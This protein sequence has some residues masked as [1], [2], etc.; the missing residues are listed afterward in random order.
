MAKRPSLSHQMF[1]RLEELKCIGESRHEAKRVAKE[2]G[3][4]VRGIYSYKTYDAYKNSSKQ[5][6]SW[7]KE[8]YNEVKY[9][10]DITADMAK[11][12]I[13]YREAEGHS[14]YTYSQDMA[15]INKTLNLNITKKDC[16]VANRNLDTIKNSRSD[17]GFRTKT[18]A[19]EQF[20]EGTGLRR[21]ELNY[22]TKKD[23]IYQDNKVVGVRVS[24]GGKGGKT[25]VA[26]VHP[27]YQKKIYTQ[28]SML[29]SDDKIIQEEIPKELQ[30]HRIRGEYAK[31]MYKELQN[32]GLSTKEAK[33][34]LTNSMGHNRVSVLRHYGVN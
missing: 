11:N 30:T 6:V 2:Q 7:I 21:N 29:K 3:E 27:E 15:M 17:N 18:G 8:N 28:I 10:K 33:Q 32:K 12:Y 1:S 26:E 16:G 34:R 9:I 14:A 19:I 5:F 22:V 4:K 24:K 25:R 20:V 31:K 23:C 13:K